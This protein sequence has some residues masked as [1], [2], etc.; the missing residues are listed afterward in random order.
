[1][2]LGKP[3]PDILILSAVLL[4][5]T[6]YAIIA[7]WCLTVYVFD[8]FI[9]SVSIPLQLALLLTFFAGGAHLCALCTYSGGV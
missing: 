6:F 5:R 4:V 1:M 9:C 8:S 7:V 3:F 2:D